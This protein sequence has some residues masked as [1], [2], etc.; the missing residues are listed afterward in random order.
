MFSTYQLKSRF[1]AVLRPLATRLHFAGVT[2][3][4]ITIG[5][6]L[7][8]VALGLLVFL[9]PGSNG[10]FLLISLWCLLRMA[11]NALDG[12]LAREF[13]QASH[14]GAVLNEM[15]DMI[16]DIALYLPFAL[17]AGSEPL[18]VV[19]AALLVVITELI[20]WLA[21]ALNHMR[22]NHGPMGKSDRAMA[23]GVIALLIGFD[24][25]LDAFINHL[26]LGIIILLLLTLFNRCRHVL[27]TSSAGSSH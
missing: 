12:I 27:A 13:N 10:I 3:N 19:I 8:S 24:I 23:F 26:W 4:Q 22:P 6:C 20:S 16:S 17:V 21:S 7:I 1:Q 18:L 11:A 15:G 9:F 25:S 14:L 2:P 5:A